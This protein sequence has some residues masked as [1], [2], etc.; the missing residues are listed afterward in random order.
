VLLGTFLLRFGL[1]ARDLR[2][3]GLPEQ[4][5]ALRALNEEQRKALDVYRTFGKDIAEL[6]RL[7]GEGP[8]LEAT[9]VSHEA[10]ADELGRLQGE[11]LGA[12]ENESNVT[13]LWH[14]AEQERDQEAGAKAPLYEEIGKLQGEV[15]RARFEQ[16]EAERKEAREQEQLARL[17]AAHQEL[18]GAHRDLETQLEMTRDTLQETLGTLDEVQGNL[19]RLTADHHQARDEADRLQDQLRQRT[20]ERDQLQRSPEYRLGDLLL[21]RLGLRSPLRLAEKSLRHLGHRAVVQ[22][23]VADGVTWPWKRKAD[24]K[25]MVTICWNFPIYSQTFVYQ[26]LIQLIERGGFDLRIA[27]S[28]LEP[29]SHLPAQFD[30]LWS[31]KRYQVLDQAISR[32]DFQAYQTRMPERVEEILTT[33]SRESG[34]DREAILDHGNFLQAFSYAR[35][36]EAYRPDYLHSYFFYDRTLFSW[37]ASVLL[38]LPRGVSCYA[39]HVMDDY[40]FKVVP[41][42]LR[43]CDVVV[44]TSKR[45]KRELLE[46]APET[47]PNKIIVKPNAVDVRR[48]PVMEREEPAE[49]RPFRVVTTSRIEPKKGLIT[50]ARAAKRLRDRGVRVEFHLL[51]EADYGIQASLDYK[52]R[53]LAEIERL[54]LWGVVHLEGRQDFAGIT[55]FLQMSSLFIAPFVET[56]TGDKDGIPTALLEG[57]A[58]GLP[59][60]C[61]DAGSMTEVVTPGTDGVIVPQ[62]DAAAL[63]DAI[64]ELLGDPAR[65][66]AM[67]AA[68]A[69]KIRKEFDV[70]VCERRF[71][72]RVLDILARRRAARDRA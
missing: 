3:K 23:M 56:A 50:L 34:V 33:L 62:R 15:E 69:L 52:E 27:Y 32:A 40:E 48:F 54:D 38:D 60:V 19:G 49:D 51:G 25:A 20:A 53:L 35:M 21:T 6:Y 7:R 65:R 30:A 43:T 36:A 64:E 4:L 31:K 47:D 58:T 11:F 66:A 42:H 1:G 70:S 29:R 22:R 63:A 44:A 72:D 24:Y 5:Q 2:R 26:E 10:L 18:E 13:R 46:I 45:I 12:L 67:G 28:K 68:A 37:I 8:F 14:Q 55:G 17:Q 39:D 9:R 59:A 71:H 57:M 41:L 61:S 16:S